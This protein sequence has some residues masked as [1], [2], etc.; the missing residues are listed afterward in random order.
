MNIFGRVGPR[1]LSTVAFPGL[2]QAFQ[3]K[4]RSADSSELGIRM[5]NSLWTQQ[6]GISQNEQLGLSERLELLETLT[7]KD[8]PSAVTCKDHSFGSHSSLH[9]CHLLGN[10]LA[11]LST[12]GGSLGQPVFPTPFQNRDD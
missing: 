11:D 4:P 12:P 1:S 2:W 8:N 7:K 6:I 9:H 10:V 5:R 3:T